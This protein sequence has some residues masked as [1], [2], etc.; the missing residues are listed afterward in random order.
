[1]PFDLG[2]WSPELPGVARFPSVRIHPDRTSALRH[3]LL[4]HQTGAPGPRFMPPRVHWGRWQ[5]AEAAAAD[6]PWPA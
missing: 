2:Y 1:M 3:C 6:R 5:S 4:F